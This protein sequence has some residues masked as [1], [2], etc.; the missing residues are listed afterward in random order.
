MA[1]LIR[2]DHERCQGAGVCVRRAPGTFSLGSDR[3]SRVAESPGDGDAM[4]RDA[5]NA[6]PFFAIEVHT[7]DAD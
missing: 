5:A 4:I 2:V 1:L 6:C 3:R 7:P